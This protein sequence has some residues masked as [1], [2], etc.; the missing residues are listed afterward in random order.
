MSVIYTPQG[1]PFTFERSIYSLSG[2]IDPLQSIMDQLGGHASTLTF[3]SGHTRATILEKVS[4]HRC[5]AA[6][7][8]P[9]VGA[10]GLEVAAGWTAEGGT[11]V[12][13]CMGYG[14]ALITGKPAA[15]GWATVLQA[16][17][18]LAAAAAAAEWKALG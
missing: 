5:W 6:K 2:R 11:A 8:S 16:V 4:C 12:K 3:F 18:V 9:L 17:T 13:P 15:A 14:G 7:A 10:A 1:D